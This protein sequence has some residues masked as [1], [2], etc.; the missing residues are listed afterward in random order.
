MIFEVS[1]S[2]LPGLPELKS[3]DLIP[4][5]FLSV[6]EDNISNGE[7]FDELNYQTDTEILWDI[8]SFQ[9]LSV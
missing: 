5:D 6:D 7:S 1:S 9:Y 3:K 4:W 2:M 8:F